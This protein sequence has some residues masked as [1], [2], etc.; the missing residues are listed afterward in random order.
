[1]SIS[2]MSWAWDQPA[3]PVE[4]LVLLALAD[5]ADHEHRSYMSHAAVNRK[6]GGDVSGTLDALME[7]G[8][9]SLEAANHPMT[10]EPCTCFALW[11]ES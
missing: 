7:K 5:N 9:I 1:M 10:G 3:A 8:F 4:K 11:C 2:A 6:C